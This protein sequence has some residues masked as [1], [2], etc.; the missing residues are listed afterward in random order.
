[1]KAMACVVCESSSIHDRSR[2]VDKFGKM[3]EEVLSYS[4]GRHR[5]SGE[6]CATA[7]QIPH[8]HRSPREE[9]GTASRCTPRP[10]TAVGST[11]PRSRLVCY[12]ASAWEGDESRPWQNCKR[13]RRHGTGRRT[14]TI[15]PSTGSSRAPRH[16]GNLATK[17][18]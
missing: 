1:M 12:R 4:S 6:G 11:W 8:H 16:A 14:A 13:K 15:P 10:N 18:T 17:E 7:V 9:S 3:E 5:C 2:E